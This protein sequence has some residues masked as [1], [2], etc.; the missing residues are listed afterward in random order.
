ML[1]IQERTQA[2]CQDAICGL[3]AGGR[4]LHTIVGWLGDETLR[5]LVI[6]EQK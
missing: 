4:N 6:S 5:V 2:P 3:R 1:P